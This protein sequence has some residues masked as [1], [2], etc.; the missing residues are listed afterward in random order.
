MT[1]SDMQ[2]TALKVVD[3]L[4]PKLSEFHQT[5][6][7]FAEPAWREY[8]SAAAY[9]DL[10]RAE[11]FQVEAGSA[12]MPTAFCATWGESGPVIGLYAEYDA[13]PGYSQMP[14]PRREPR[15]EF[16]RWAPGWTDAHSALGVGA[17]TGALALKQVIE[18]TGGS[19]RI[20]LFGEPAEKVCGS[21]AVHA[22]HGYYDD[23]DAT[24]S[25][26]PGSDNVAY[27][28]IQSCLYASVVFTFE[29]TETEPWGLSGGSADA[30]PHSSV[31]S[32]GAVDAA[33]LMLTAVKYV[34]ENMYPRTGLWSLNEVI[35][36]AGNATADNLP[37]RIAHVQYSVRSPL[38]EIQDQV[39]AILRREAVHAAQM[40]NCEV[41]FRWVTAVRPGLAN[42]ALANAT[43]ENI[44]AI[45]PQE[46]DPSVFEFGRAIERELGLEPS[47][48]PFLPGIFT[49]RSPQ[50]FDAS[51]RKILPPWQGC[52][53][54]D[55]YTEY[56]WHSP[57]V[58][59]NTAKPYLRQAPGRSSW[60][61]NA[62]NGFAPAIDQMW[63]Y[64][65]K[66]LCSVG[67]RLIEEEGL[68]AGITEEFSRRREAAPAEFR[69]PLLPK[70]FQAP[71]DL[72]WPEYIQT[73]RGF[74][75]VVP[76]QTVQGERLA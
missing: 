73:A 22:V 51:R 19:G 15:P 27:G 33:A 63:I 67:V 5:I 45:G 60:A 2:Q 38:K 10:L 29:C 37:P 18:R 25:Y 69:E 61:N 16:S 7:G 13:S 6:W 49:T 72:P 58:R 35:L 40:T 55:D 28:E 11:G 31:R 47:D 4:T 42:T 59:I 70:G 54:A 62:F 48:N 57:A 44:V 24:L 50:E 36:G 64:A 68:L 17:L 76:R 66:V 71:V 23:I 14:V 52:T 9:V 34:K 74:D 20:K 41:S 30:S 43:H 46:L 12:G 26:H 32:P 56:T 3:E 39:I 75:W 53:G 21:K 1:L 8:R 65:G